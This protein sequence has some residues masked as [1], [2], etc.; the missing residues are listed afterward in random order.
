M[1][2]AFHAEGL[3][4]M[5]A[6][7]AGL[8]RENGRAAKAVNDARDPGKRGGSVGAGLLPIARELGAQM[9]DQAKGKTAGQR[10][11]S[12]FREYVFLAVFADAEGSACVRGIEE[13]VM[14]GGIAGS[15]E[16]LGEIVMRG[17]G[18]IQ[19]EEAGG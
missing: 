1:P 15:T 2:F 18:E 7:L 14:G 8:A 16:L 17:L 12:R 4:H 13:E 11:R 19:F 10:H 3:G 5:Q 6:V 9:A